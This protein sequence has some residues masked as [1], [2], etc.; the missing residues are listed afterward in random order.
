[1]S[2]GSEDIGGDRGENKTLILQKEGA[3]ISLQMQRG[4]TASDRRQLARAGSEVAL[5]LHCI[6]L[7]CIVLHCIT[8]Y[9]NVLHC[10]TL[11]YTCIALNCTGVALYYTVLRCIAHGTLT[12]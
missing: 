5:E 6:T 4:R 3:R 10:V 9:C 12:Y 7:Y 8:Q 1:M 2:R 11:Y